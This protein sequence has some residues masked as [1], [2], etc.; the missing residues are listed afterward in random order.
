MLQNH[1]AFHNEQHAVSKAKEHES[2]LQY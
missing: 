2:Y 1:V